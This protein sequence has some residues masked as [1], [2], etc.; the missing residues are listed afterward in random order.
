MKRQKIKGNKL[1]ETLPHRDDEIDF[2]HSAWDKH[3]EASVPHE[4][5]TV[6]PTATE[7]V[8]QIISTDVALLSHNAFRST[9]FPN[10]SP[11]AAFVSN[12]APRKSVEEN[13]EAISD[14]SNSSFCSLIVDARG[15]SFQTSAMDASLLQPTPLRESLDGRMRLV[16]ASRNV[17]S[18]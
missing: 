11:L 9:H 10:V 13:V 18:L 15:G 17:Y 8:P 2:Y 14:D 12:F 3:Y 4:L 16:D 7:G 5:Q 6:R 1:H